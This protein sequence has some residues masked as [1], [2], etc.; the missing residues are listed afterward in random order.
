MPK[1]KDETV[2]KQPTKKARVQEMLSASAVSVG[3][4]AEALAISKQAAYS[5]IGDVKRSG[6]AITGTLVE[7]SMRY[8]I[9]KEKRTKAKA[10]AFGKGAVVSAEPSTDG[11]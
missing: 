4:I 6:V 11:R 7:G 5:L 1:S 9:A 8:S 3:E 10:A 2:A